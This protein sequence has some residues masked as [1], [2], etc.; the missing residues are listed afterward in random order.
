MDRSFGHGKPTC[1]VPRPRTGASPVEVDRRGRARARPEAP[2]AERPAVQAGPREY[3]APPLP[4]Q[5]LEKPGLEARLE[6]HPRFDA[7]AYEGS[8]KLRD[9]IAIVT[10]G[11]SGIGRAVAVLFAREARTSPSCT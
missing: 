2:A 9:R 11:D 7:P 4:R 6:P 8:G 10:G 3:P 5:H 1:A